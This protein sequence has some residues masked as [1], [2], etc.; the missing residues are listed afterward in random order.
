MEPIPLPCVP[1]LCQERG[2]A[3]VPVSATNAHHRDVSGERSRRWTH[4]LGLLVF[5]WAT[6]ACGD[7]DTPPRPP[8]AD[9]SPQDVTAEVEPDDAPAD[10]PPTDAFD[11]HD[12]FDRWDL[13]EVEA[14]L[15]ADPPPISAWVWSEPIAEWPGALLSVSGTSASDVWVVGAGPDAAATVLHWDGTSWTEHAGVSARTLWW[16]EATHPDEVWFGG[17]EGTLLRWDGETF[18]NESPPLLAR[19]TV[20][21]VTRDA[22]GGV[23]AVGGQGGRG[24]FLWSREGNS[25][26]APSLPE[27][28]PRLPHGD[29]AS[30]FKVASHADA[31]WLVGG[32]GQAFYG[33]AGGPFVDVGPGGANPFFTVAVEPATG[34]ALAVGGAGQGVIASL[35][36]PGS[37]VVFEDIPLL[38][39]VAFG[40]DG[41]AWVAGANGAVLHEE[42]GAWHRIAYEGQVP[43]ESLHAIWIDPDGNV[44]AVGGNVLGASLDRGVLLHGRR[45]D[46]AP[47]ASL[48]PPERVE[49]P[50]TCPH[51]VSVPADVSIARFW[52]ELTLASI[53]RAMPEPT[54]H[55]RNLYHLSLAVHDAWAA[56][57][58]DVAGLILDVSFD[59]PSEV[60]ALVSYAAYRLLVHR[61]AHR[62]G[63][64]VSVACFDQ[65]LE[66]LGL[67]RPETSDAAAAD[68]GTRIGQ[69]VIDAFARDGSLEHL[70]YQDASWR[71]VNPSLVIDEPGIDLDDPDRWQPLDL[72]IAITQN[73][74]AESSGP[75]RYIGPHWGS[76]VPFALRLDVEDA[77]SLDSGPG[78]RMASPDMGA[79]ALDVLRRTAWLDVDDGVFIDISPGARGNVPLGDW[80]GSGHP[81]NPATGAPYAPQ[82][83]RRGDFGR[84][85]AEHWADGPDSE[86]PPG[87]WNVLA[88]RAFDDPRF[89]RRWMGEGPVLDRLTWDVRALLVLN[90]ALHDAA[91]IAWGVKRTSEGARPISL[92]RWMASLGQRSEPSAADYHPDGLPLEEGLVE[93]IT[94]ETTR[95]GGRHA[96]LR[97]HEGELAVWTWPGEPAER[98]VRRSP[99]RWMRA[100]EWVPYQPRTFVTPA[101][102]GFVSGH[103]TFSRT[104]ADVLTG[105]TGSAFVPGGIQEYVAPAG[106]G[107]HFEHG[108]T[109]DI[110][111]A[112]ATWQDAADQAGESRIWGGIHILPD[113]LVGRR[114]GAAIAVRALAWADATFRAEGPGPGVPVGPPSSEPGDPD[115]PDDPELPFVPGAPPTGDA[116]LVP[117]AGRDGDRS[118]LQGDPVSWESGVQGGHHIWV[119]A[120]LE[121]L[122]LAGLSDAVRRDVRT[123]FQLTRA[124]G[125]ELGDLVRIGGY[126]AR[127]GAWDL[128]GN[129]M[130]LRPGLRPRRLDD[131]A[132]R[133]D[134]SVEIPDGPTLRRTVWVVSRCCDLEGL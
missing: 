74:L 20:F 120:R 12:G 88:H 81:A 78:P 24:G 34:R 16:V 37:P 21:G 132:L 89:E 86:T 93:R 69:A 57:Q 70:D 11:S 131:E 7:P 46:A 43:I 6:S 71:S 130:V 22:D 31:L 17:D 59:D 122:V 112:W 54:V 58:D 30:L 53:R 15:P 27:E 96:A 84:V 129:F 44:W 36:P 51:P 98:H 125:E 94:S 29:T 106:R 28:R 39:G 63:G 49:V 127:D 82:R 68:V 25:W 50:V 48:A 87:H 55:A 9:A 79:W 114:L 116:S 38:Q 92:I 124:D 5:A 80:V 85:L 35:Q 117:A 113:D 67:A 33:P 72:A 23:H 65:A 62:R 109:E 128:W 10:I 3:V 26:H 105:I 42:D 45:P 14:D 61:Y 60:D 66:A 134:V 91:V 118:L 1:Q 19:H 123:R 18:V 133:L 104:A 76:V 40:P 83:V 95:P 75:Q 4:R 2:D 100:V 107:L 32:L 77:P 102:P 101:F 99:F 73:G 64:A 47:V 126:R 41:R 13:S 90:G 119:A 111:L 110:R 8:E 56:T 108:P 121:D 97:G 115:P 103:S 52:N